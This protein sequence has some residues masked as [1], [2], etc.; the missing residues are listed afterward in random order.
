MKRGGVI[1]SEAYVRE[2]LD[3]A[4]KELKALKLR[5]DALQNENHALKKS[6]FELSTR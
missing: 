5:N 2:Q 3:S 1:G 6:V 4:Q